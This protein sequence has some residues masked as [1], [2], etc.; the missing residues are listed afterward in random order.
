MEAADAAQ[1]YSIQCWHTLHLK[2][3]NA[4][5]IQPKYTANRPNSRGLI[6]REGGFRPDTDPCAREE[7]HWRHWCQGREGVVRLVTSFS[8]P[9]FPPA[10]FHLT[11]ALLH[12]LLAANTAAS[13][14]KE[15]K[16]QKPCEV[17]VLL[18]TN[19]LAHAELNLLLNYDL[20]QVLF[21]S[22]HWIL[23]CRRKAMPHSC[24]NHCC[25][26]LWNT[27]NKKR[28]SENSLVAQVRMSV[29]YE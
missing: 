9:P 21:I 8:V 29:S 28:C 25:F 3:H 11:P 6:T 17:K 10:T 12:L 20:Q 26:L 5:W 15:N 18:Q 14:L 16:P 19:H 22:W 13:L 24:Q 7:R 1:L 27:V 4:P 23:T 2:Q